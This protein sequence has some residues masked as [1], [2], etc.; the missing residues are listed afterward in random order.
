MLVSL[1]LTQLLEYRRVAAGLKFLRSD[2]SI[3]LTDGIDID[4]ADAASLRHRYL[5]LLDTAPAH[6]LPTANV[7]PQITLTLG[8][9]FRGE[10]K[11]P[12]SCRRLLNIRLSTW[13]RP[14]LPERREEYDLSPRRRK[15][16]NPLTCPGPSEP[17]AVTEADGR[18]TVI[19]AVKNCT[20]ASAIAVVD[21]GEDTFTLDE[22]LLPALAG[23]DTLI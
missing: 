9:G 11:L 17:V 10:A 19:P 23:V 3:E 14:A 1:N 20:V 2:C 21:P 13:M 5:Q 8:A 18:V 4:G 22:S 7:A 6:L 16:L 15:E 12:P